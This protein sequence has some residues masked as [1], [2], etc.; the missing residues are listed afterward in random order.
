MANQSLVFYTP[1]DLRSDPGL[2]TTWNSLVPLGNPLYRAFAGPRP[3]QTHAAKEPHAGNRVAMI[4]DADGKAVGVCP[5]V[6]WN[7]SIPLQVRKRIFGKIKL[8]AATILCGEPLVPQDPALF[9]MLFNGLLRE[10]TWCDCLY[11]NSIPADCFTSRFIYGGEANFARFF[12]HPKRLERREWLY[13]ELDESLEAYLHTKH[14]R[15]RNTW[16]RRVKKLR[17]LG[18]GMLE[19]ERIENEDQIEDFYTAGYSIAENSWQFHSLGMA[20]KD[21]AL[22]RETLLSYARGGCLRAYLLKCGGRPCAFVIGVQCQDAVQFE[23]TAYSRE[24]AVHSPG[25]VL[26]YMLL[27]DIYKYR[28]PKY[29]NFGTGVNPHKR[30]FSNRESFDTAIYLFR[31]SLRNRLRATTNRLF[32]ATLGLAKRL[33]RKRAGTTGDDGESEES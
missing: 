21:T 19:C 3:F 11:F 27:E 10:M 31:R 13:H 17:E 6:H 5:V 8:Q 12:V 16:K 23:Q 4:R 18:N 15:T 2:Q 25:T 28:R 14:K 30:L 32:Y 7:L 20:L 24:F 26:Y 1:E 29:L 9:Q 22:Y 33:S